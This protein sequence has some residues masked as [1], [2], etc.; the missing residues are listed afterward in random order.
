MGDRPMAEVA[1]TGGMRRREDAGGQAGQRPQTAAQTSPGSLRVV[2]ASGGLQASSR[3]D[4]PA[5]RAVQMGR[6][7]DDG[8]VAAARDELYV[9]DA[10]TLRFVEVSAGAQKNLGYGPDELQWMTPVDIKPM[11]R[12]AFE[13]MVAPLRHG[14]EELRF[15]TTHQ[16]KNGTLYPVQVRLQLVRGEERSLFL[17]V[18]Q[19]LTERRRIDALLLG[20]QQVLE[21]MARNATA[22][23]LLA[24]I[25]DWIERH[26]P[27]VHC[28]VLLLDGQG[29]MARHVAP[30][31]PG[32]LVSVLD[33]IDFG[34][35]ASPCALAAVAGAP[36]IVGDVTLETR[37]PLWQEVVRAHG[38]QACWSAPILAAC[39]QVVGVFSLY[40]EVTAQASSE[41][42]SLL[43]RAAHLAAI[44]IE[45]GKAEQ[46]AAY[47]SHFDDLTGLPN[48]SLLQERVEK[49]LMHARRYPRMAAV[50]FVGLDRWPQMSSLGVAVE[51]Q[52]LQHAAQRLLA[53]TR[54]T[55]TA[56]RVGSQVFAVLLTDLQGPAAVLSACQRIR[57]SLRLPL[58]IGSLEIVL[59]PSIGVSLYPQDADR[60]LDLIQCAAVAL[61]QSQALG[62]ARCQFYRQ[63][64]NEWV[65]ERWALEAELRQALAR[66]ELCLEYQ[67]KADLASGR[68][69]GVEALLRWRHPVRGTIPPAEFIPVAED[70]GLIIPIGAWVLE[71]A[72]RQ[73]RHWQDL[74]LPPIGMAVNLSGRQLSDPDLV[75]FVRRVL[76][77]T[78]LDPASLE[79]ELTESILM[80]R[81]E[82]NVAIL[83]DIK[84]LGAR[85]ALDD[86]GTGYSSLSYLTRFRVDR[87]KIDRTF[88]QNL[89][90]GSEQGAIAAAIITMAHALGL[91][92]TAEGVETEAQ[93]QMLRAQGCDEMQG[94]LLSRPLSAEDCEALLRARCQDQTRSG[95]R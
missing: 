42:I 43:M 92:V 49:A 45:R 86:F 79:L 19:D 85:L 8:V 84:R 46:R 78:G 54:E 5:G 50:L 23:D 44:A 81:V 1:M 88:V 53:V 28:A 95:G 77:E 27:Q 90:H 74:G 26:Y 76:T 35:D 21:Q 83:N 55:D 13:A 36:V 38:F 29:R 47:L 57:D 62:N 91:V 31:L 64:T 66:R 41:Q 3:A 22:N 72:C 87:L 34:A 89:A 40:L 48:R 94:Y 67:P 65:Q 51:E 73:S 56:A 32:P 12:D 20:E 39:D 82:D 9:F 11:D 80:D 6:A 17:A 30:G 10:E 93:Q 63:A 59:S 2:R 18:V 15:E 14:T 4:F 16:R 24:V 60:A 58:V 75:S 70:S 71:T 69:T 25:T 68:I 52:A 7:L 61:Q 37:W 33:G